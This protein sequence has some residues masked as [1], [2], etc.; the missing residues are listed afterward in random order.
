VPSHGALEIEASQTRN[1]FASAATVEPNAKIK[2]LGL[3]QN[4]TT[5]ETATGEGRLAARGRISARAV[6]LKPVGG[7]ER[8]RG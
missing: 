8:E 1:I 3:S 5:T 6:V 7:Q 4:Q 2:P